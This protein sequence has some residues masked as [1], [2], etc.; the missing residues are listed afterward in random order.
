MRLLLTLLLLQ[1]LL[2]VLAAWLLLLL[3]CVFLIGQGHTSNTSAKCNGP[4]IGTLAF[5]CRLF[6]PAAM[7]HCCMLCYGCCPTAELLGCVTRVCFCCWHCWCAWSLELQLL[8]CFVLV[9]CVFCG[10]CGLWRDWHTCCCLSLRFVSRTCTNLQR[11]LASLLFFHC[12]SF[13]ICGR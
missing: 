11:L 10:W 9:V 4:T 3:V 8:M 13:E 6:L 5:Q 12:C 2:S 1:W 7:R